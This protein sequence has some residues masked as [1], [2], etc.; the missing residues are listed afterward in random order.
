MITVTDNENQSSTTQAGTTGT[1]GSGRL[2]GVRTKAS[3]AFQSARDRTSS[4]YGSA[5]ERA[6]GAS[7][8][9]AETIDTAPGAALIGGLALGAL[10]AVLLPK[11][12]K[13]EELLGSYGRQINDKAKQAAQAAKEAGRSK[14]DEL[15]LKDTA[16]Q[17]LSDVASQAKDAVKQT[18]TAAAQAAKTTA[19]TGQGQSGQTGSGQFGSGQAS[20]GVGT[21]ADPFPTV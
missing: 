20:S 16:K 10:A 6:S 4:A 18:A 1:E 17:A 19:Q 15:G 21:T 14:I 11:T 12:R 5:R 13:E 8:K 3:D 9:T 2:S 7:R